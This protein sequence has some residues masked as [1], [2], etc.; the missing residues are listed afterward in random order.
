M[1]MVF[2]LKSPKLISLLIGTSLLTSC[3]GPKMV[4]RDHSVTAP[5]NSRALTSSTALAGATHQ[6]LRDEDLLELYRRDPGEAVRVLAGRYDQQPN[7]TRRRALAEIVSD[8]GDILTKDRP[9]EAIGHYL[10]AARLSQEAALDSLGGDRESLD[11]TIYNY[12]AARVARILHD[13]GNSAKTPVVARG[14]LRTY[15]LDVA[16]GPHNVNPVD[17]DLIVP[18]D[19]IKMRGLKLARVTEDGFGM[20]MVGHRTGTDERRASDPNM[21][22]NGYGFALNASFRFTGS[23][24]TLVLQ[25]LMQS[26]RT[27]V[28]G[29]RVPLAGDYTAVLAFIYYEREQRNRKVLA[30]LHPTK[31]QDMIGLY[32]VE[33]FR[34]D[35]IPLILVHGLLS[36][37][38]SWL[39]FSNLLRADP[40]VREKYQIVLFNYPNGQPISQSAK[41]LRSA[42]AE[43]RQNH[44]PRGSNPRM[45]EMVIV[46]HSM[47]GILSNLQIRDSGDHLKDLIFHPTIEEADLD[48]EIQGGV[49]KLL[50]FKSNPDIARAVFMATPHRGSAFAT[51]PIGRF[52]AW[53]I[54]FPLDLVDGVLGEI[55]V[56]D[57]LTDVGQEASMRPR[58]SV[59][60]LRPDNP[61]LPAIL[62]LPVRQGVPIHSVIAQRN[63][64]KPLVESGDGVVPYTSSHLGGVASEKIILGS[65]HRVMV[66]DD[67]TIRELWRILRLHAGVRGE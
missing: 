55:E 66:E 30:M 44:D 28:E 19:W 6:T 47:G 40:L 62:D 21:P 18:V 50:F 58:N 59:N 46:G 42:L 39:P 48:P 20:A 1:R 7:E 52:G 3:G 36:T 27:R 15:R 41:Q 5:Q 31:F 61:V 54:R 51:N 13:E 26:A 23:K 43:F 45:R 10:D 38:E 17:F 25:D 57:A 11:R 67:D 14:S 24:A 16:S 12:C 8:T 49:E 64:N 60:S 35:K 53:L 22:S 63:V 33:P 29:R 56:I 9:D 2:P 34:E 65:N 4:M 37:A 32:S